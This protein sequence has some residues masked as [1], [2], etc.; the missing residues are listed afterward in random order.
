M[1]GGIIEVKTNLDATG[2]KEAIEHFERNFEN[3]L[4]SPTEVAFYGV[5]L[6]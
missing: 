6:L 5:F 3:E 4:L 2:L 1:L